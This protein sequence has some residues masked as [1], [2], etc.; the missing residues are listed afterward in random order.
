MKTISTLFGILLAA[1]IAPA[2]AQAPG[3]VIDEVIAVVGNDIVLKSELENQFQSLLS[4]GADVENSTRC[5]VYENLLFQSLLLNQAKEDSLEVREDQIQSEIDRRLNFFINQI[6]SVEKLEEFYDKSIIEI[7]EEFHDIIKSQLLVQ[8]MQGKL[9]GEL[10]VTPQD[11][12]E[13]FRAIPKDSLPFI[14][15]E[16]EVAHLVKEPPISKEEKDRTREKL[17]GILER[18]RQGEN[19]GTLAYLYSEDPGSARKNGELGFMPRRALVPEFSAVAFKL[20]KGAISDIVETEYGYHIIQMVARRGEEVN[21]RHI[22][23]A[24]KVSNADLFK[25]KAYLD[26]LYTVIQTVD[27]MTFE[28]VTLDHSSDKDTRNNGG[29]MVNPASGNTRFTLEELGQ[30][31][32]TLTFTL[33]EMAPGDISEPELMYKPDGT[34]AYRIVKLVM[35]TEPHRANL[36]DDYNYLSDLA[37]EEKRTSHI[38]TWVTKKSSNTYVRLDPNFQSCNF[39][40]NWS[41]K[42]TA[43][44]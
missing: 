15:A 44:K 23:L 8:Q 25:A 4:S 19:F 11:I 41:N 2:F 27:T 30:I 9:A 31:D 42:S 1:A 18:V 34:K 37:L 13:Y 10:S 3:K 7:K 32:P 40:Y 29:K 35:A 22:L 17:E 24:P 16:V 20:K 5:E 28:R 36:K 12:R 14:E 39:R 26:S 21:V 6:G 38:E 33:N 43:E